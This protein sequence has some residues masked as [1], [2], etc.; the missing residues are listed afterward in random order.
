MLTEPRMDGR[1]QIDEHGRGDGVFRHRQQ[2]D[3]ASSMTDREVHSP[4]PRSRQADTGVNAANNQNAAY[5]ASKGVT[6]NSLQNIG[7]AKTN[8]AMGL[9][10]LGSGL[11]GGALKGYNS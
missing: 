2:F 11:L 4:Q 5:L 10:S 9:A 8:S 3:G 1:Q 7:A 6:V